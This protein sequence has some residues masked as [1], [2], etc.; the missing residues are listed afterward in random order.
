LL[1]EKEQQRIKEKKRKEGIVFET[2]LHNYFYLT[3]S[4]TLKILKKISYLCL[5][6]VITYEK[7]S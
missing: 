1:F 2:M 3:I 4:K 5:G 7:S 6:S